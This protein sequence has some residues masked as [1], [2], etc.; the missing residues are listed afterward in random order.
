MR[1]LC[2]TI[3]IP[4]KASLEIEN[5]IPGIKQQENGNKG[6]IRTQ[7]ILLK[8]LWVLKRSVDVEGA[9]F[10]V[11][12]PADSIEELRDRYIEA[13]G[14]VQAKFFEGKN[15]VRISRTYVEERGKP[16]PSFFAIL[17][18]DTLDGEPVSY[19]FTAAQIASFFKLSR[20]K[21]CYI[22]RLTNTR[23]YSQFRNVSENNIFSKII[24]GVRHSSAEKGSA[25]LNS[26]YRVNEASREFQSDSFVYMLRNIEGVNVV[27]VRHE[28]TKTG[29][30]K[31]LEPRRD[32]FP[33]S[34]N[35]SWGYIGSGPHF[36]CASILG[37]HLVHRTPTTAEREAL[38][39]NVVCKFSRAPGSENIF[40]ITTGMIESAIRDTLQIRDNYVECFREEFGELSRSSL[41]KEMVRFASPAVIAML[42][43]ADTKAVYKNP[44]EKF[45][46]VKFISQ[47]DT[48][49][50]EIPITSESAK[51]FMA[52][53]AIYSGEPQGY[54]SP[55][56]SIQLPE[57]EF[58]GY[59][60]EATGPPVTSDFGF[61]ITKSASG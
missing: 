56:L 11:Q 37:H 26:F 55:I 61:C 16:R 41:I 35:F 54:A 24:E 22:F 34:G 19:F 27:L 30:A 50:D 38:M 14:L 39:R 47:P 51:H 52:A 18:T 6:E 17:H 45:I 42:R 9:D 60:L 58:G 13:F 3:L 36:L 32:I 2:A 29:M 25:V 15:Q 12:L 48:S 53:S 23:D 59:W 31:L 1:L 43:R 21:E 40:N 46:R 57:K 20:C 4:L 28:N 44:Q 5:M 7:N 33:Y 8:K 10:L 49:L